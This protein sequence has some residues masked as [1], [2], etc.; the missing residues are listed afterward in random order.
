MIRTKAELRHYISEDARVNGMEISW[1]SYAM[2]LIYGNVNACVFRYLKSLRKYEF[3]SNINSPIRYWWRYRNRRLGLK[4]NLA[5][6]IN[7]VAQGLYLPH[8]EGGVI[9]NC[10][11]MGHNC[12][13][14]SGVVIGNKGDNSNIATIGSNVQLCVG[15]KVIGAITIG[16]NV[17]V[18]PNA[19]VV[20]DVPDNCIVGGVPAKII[21]VF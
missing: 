18:A 15:A 1:V 11:S 13:I 20:K 17:I 7:V 8:I 3:Y 19:V 16:N 2:R 12:I 14:N 4:Y 10:K 6:P 21:K 5:I 9:V